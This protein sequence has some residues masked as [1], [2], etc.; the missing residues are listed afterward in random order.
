MYKH[1]TL[2][3]LVLMECRSAYLI[4]CN[5]A[6]QI[7]CYFCGTDQFDLGSNSKSCNYSSIKKER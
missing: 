2:K 1:A 5:G 3:S 4:N 7:P 6:A